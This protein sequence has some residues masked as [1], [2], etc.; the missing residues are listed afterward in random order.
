MGEMLL[1]LSVPEVLM[2]YGLQYGRK[3]CPCSTSPTSSM[4]SRRL[5][6]FV[7]DWSA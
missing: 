7:T 4:G 2:F 1:F 3:T 5:T 6:Q